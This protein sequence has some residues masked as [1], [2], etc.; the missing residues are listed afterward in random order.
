M[1][2][3][4]LSD[5]EI[6]KLR[7]LLRERAEHVSEQDLR[8]LLEKQQRAERQLSVL[9]ASLPR[10]AS[11]VRLGFGLIK[12]YVQGNYRKLPWWSV[13]SVA[14][15]LGY[16][17]TPTDMLPDFLPGIGYLDDATILTLV[18]AGIREDVKKYAEAKGIRLE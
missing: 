14:A 13:A 1:E 12:D 9:S 15:A 4:P 5:Q 2:R 10:L 3:E 16:F 6:E 7:A 17:V 8:A 11:N 18:M